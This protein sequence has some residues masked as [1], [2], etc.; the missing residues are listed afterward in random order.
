MWVILLVRMWVEIY[1]G[2]YSWKPGTSSSSWGCE[3]KYGNDESRSAWFSVILLVRMWVE[4]INR[5]N[6][7]INVSV[8]LLVRMWVEISNTIVSS[9]LISSSSSWGCELKCCWPSWSDIRRKVILLVRMWVE[10]EILILYFHRILRHPPREDVSWNNSPSVCVSEPP[11]SSSS[12]GCELKYLEPMIWAIRITVILLVR[13]W[14]EI[15]KNLRNGVM[16]ASSSS[17]GCELKY[18]VFVCVGRAGCH[19][20]REDVSWNNENAP[21]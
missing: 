12:W 9:N 7:V 10:I 11:T 17:W 21:S 6:L 2:R 20:P 16:A 14:V 3:L 5:P 8:I 4:M 19:P 18:P 1:Y 15:D 13:M